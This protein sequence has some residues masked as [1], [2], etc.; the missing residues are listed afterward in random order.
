M[1]PGLEPRVLFEAY[2][3]VDFAVVERDGFAE[4]LAEEVPMET[5]QVLAR[6][7][8]GFRV[9]V[10]KDGPETCDGRSNLHSV[11]RTPSHRERV[12]FAV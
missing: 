9:I 6:G 7:A 4:T 12:S 2:L 5:S 10:D 1:E 11:P 3:D 8:V